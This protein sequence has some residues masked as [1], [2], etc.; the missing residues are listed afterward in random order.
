MESSEVKSPAQ[1]VAEHMRLADRMRALEQR[2]E[3][4]TGR[5]EKKLAAVDAQA[6]AAAVEKRVL[7]ELT[8]RFTK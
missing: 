3:V 8:R 4:F 5:T 2:V 1:L 7:D 6:I